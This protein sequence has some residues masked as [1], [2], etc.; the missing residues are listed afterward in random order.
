MRLRG[1]SRPVL[2]ITTF[3]PVMTHSVAQTSQNRTLIN[4]HMFI[5][6]QLLSSAEGFPPPINALPRT[7]LKTFDLVGLADVQVPRR[8]RF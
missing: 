1:Q 6:Q 4:I 7:L 5:K 2:S 3:G 8:Q